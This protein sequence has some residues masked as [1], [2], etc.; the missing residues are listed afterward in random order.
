MILGKSNNGRASLVEQ[1][2]NGLAIIKGDW[3]YIAPSNGALL[4]KD[5]NMETGNS[6]K[7]LL[8]NLKDDIG[9]TKNLA[10]ENP[11][12]VKELSKLLEEIKL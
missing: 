8:F 4:M 7:P 6:Q 5:K 2:M 1:G 3:K 11:E 12:K 9:E 10:V